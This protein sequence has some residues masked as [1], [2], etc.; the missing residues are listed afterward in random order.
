MVSI[1]SERRVFAPF[2]MVGGENAARGVNLYVNSSGKVVSLGG[3]N[4]L[5]V[6]KGD[7]IIIMTPGGG[8]WGK[9]DVNVDI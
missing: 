6:D 4:S 7:R 9:Y 2:G 3:K 5:E 8:G 1:L